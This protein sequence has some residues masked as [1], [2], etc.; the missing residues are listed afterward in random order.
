MAYRKTGKIRFFLV[1]LCLLG[2]AVGAIPFFLV[3][4]AGLELRIRDPLFNTDL[5]GSTARVVD[6]EEEFQAAFPIERDDEGF[7]VTIERIRSGELTLEL[8]VDRFEPATLDLSLPALLQSRVEQSLVPDFGRLAIS[9]VNARSA[10]DVLTDGATVQVGDQQMQGREQV[11]FV[12]VDPGR[13]FV[14]ASAGGY[15]G[16]TREAIAR[17]GETTTVLVPLSPEVSG[18]ERARIVLDWA[19]NPRDLDSHVILSGGSAPVRSIHVF[20]KNLRGLDRQGRPYA[21]LDVDWTN[22]EG[23]ETVTIYD[24]ID[25]VFQY[26][27]HRYA[28]S[29]TL[30][31]SE[32]KVEFITNGCSVRRTFEVPQTCDKLFWYVA[33]LKVEGSEAMIIER[34]TCQDEMPVQWKRGKAD[35]SPRS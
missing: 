31:G 30:G 19:E 22:S 11:L 34:D 4:P 1:L 8:D 28:G 12:P 29:G 2:L 27:I 32:A 15:C 25:G 23:F 16:A 10:Q 17:K 33:D 26:F 7:F 13:H 9:V 3:P 18:N 21:E 14:E 24:P 20:F 6:L 35:E 5:T